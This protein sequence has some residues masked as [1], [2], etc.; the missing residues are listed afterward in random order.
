MDSGSPASRFSL[1]SLEN[2]YPL[3]KMGER[4]VIMSGRD[5][6]RVVV[7]RIEPTYIMLD[8]RRLGNVNSGK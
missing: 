1:L 7:R 6:L 5:K 2:K 3:H 8:G 4:L